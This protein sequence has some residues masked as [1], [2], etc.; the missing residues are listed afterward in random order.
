[1]ERGAEGGIR[2]S[3]ILSNYSASSAFKSAHAYFGGTFAETKYG[4]Y[5]FN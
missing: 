3:A 4:L 5:P 1:M 2:S